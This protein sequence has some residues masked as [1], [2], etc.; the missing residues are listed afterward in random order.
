MT[1]AITSAYQDTPWEPT[2]YLSSNKDANQDQENA[3]K[4]YTGIYGGSYTTTNE[5]APTASPGAGA[6]IP[7]LGPAYQQAPDLVPN[8]PGGGAGAGAPPSGSSNPFYIDLG[9]VRTTEQQCLN[10]TSE[11]S[12]GYETLKSSVTG[13]TS[14]STIW[15]QDVEN[16][17]PLQG[18]RSG[19]G[20]V[21]TSYDKLDS[22]GKSYAA[23]IDPAMQQLL[24]Q[25]GGVIEMMGQFNALLNNGLQM[26]TYTD[27][28]SAFPAT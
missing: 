19:S 13:A 27:D 6:P 10:A 5:S 16:T 21:I 9:A 28:S 24:N 8:K 2:V 26:Y 7:N 1:S 15:G 4:Q 11:A 14:S 23:T 25:V 22:E 12:A 18:G 17:E 20:P 3:A